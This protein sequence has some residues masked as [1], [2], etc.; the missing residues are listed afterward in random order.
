MME[1]C[2]QPVS[3][4]VLPVPEEAIKAWETGDMIGKRV[5]SLQNVF[6]RRDKSFLDKDSIMLKYIPLERNLNASLLALDEYKEVDKP[7]ELV[8][9]EIESALKQVQ[10]SCFTGYLPSYTE[11]QILNRLEFI[12]Q[13]ALEKRRG[14]ITDEEIVTLKKIVE[15]VKRWY[16]LNDQ[17]VGDAVLSALFVPIQTNQQMTVSEKVKKGLLTPLNQYVE[18]CFSGLIAE[19]R[20]TPEAK[21]TDLHQAAI[22]AVPELLGKIIEDIGNGHKEE[23]QDYAWQIDEIVMLFID[24]FHHLALYNHEFE[25]A[26]EKE[27]YLIKLLQQWIALEDLLEVKTGDV[28]SKD[29]LLQNVLADTDSWF[30]NIEGKTQSSNPR[31]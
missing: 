12:I 23:V 6:L 26:Q 18:K 8:K 30:E 24:R 13:D 14:G 17:K 9:N 5:S 20:I 16:D 3:R 4:E 25:S 1:E 27:G 21:I 7:L 11:I 2:I 28:E 19:R 15:G 22:E 31:V 10:A 29:N